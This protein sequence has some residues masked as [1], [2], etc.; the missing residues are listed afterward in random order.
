M[1]TL[2]LSTPVRCHPP[3][4]LPLGNICQGIIFALIKDVEHDIQQHPCSEIA[5]LLSQFFVICHEEEIKLARQFGISVGELQC[6]Q[7][8]DEPQQ[9]IKE[10]TKRLGLSSSRVSR[11]LDRLEDNGIIIRNIDLKDRR[12]IL[13][14]LTAKGSDLAQK[15]KARI[16]QISEPAL[17][18]MPSESHEITIRVLRQM[19]DSLTR[20]RRAPRNGEMLYG[21]RAS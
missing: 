15:V 1:L 7:M 10:L 16:F 17:Q 2:N 8:F 14:T 9:A 19:L 21:N 13:V 5:C 11:I 20:Q 12:S 18:E 3:K 4:S 6:L